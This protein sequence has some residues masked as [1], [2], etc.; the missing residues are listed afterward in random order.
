MNDP[1][2][3]S[4]S[5]IP[6]A[7]R[8]GS[9][10]IAHQGSPDAAAPPATTS[11]PTSVTVS[12]PRPNSRPTG[13]MCHGLVTVRVTRPR[14]RLRK[15]RLF[16]CSS[17][18]AS[19]YRPVRIVR[20]TLRIPT[21]AARLMSPMATRKIPDTVVPQ[22]P[23]ICCSVDWSSSI[24]P[25]SA[26]IPRASRATMMKT[27]ELWPRLNQNPTLNG[28]LPSV[29]S[30]RVVLSMAAMWSASKACRRP[31]VYA[32][33]PRPMLNSCPLTW[34]SC[35]ATRKINV[36]HPTMCSSR[37]K[38]AIPMTDRRS[39]RVISRRRRFAFA[40]VV[41]VVTPSP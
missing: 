9:V 3:E 17:S 19:T 33:T 39:G 8:T 29:I 13:Y 23:V 27:T 36:P 7:K 28:R 41:V 16:S 24:A 30:F 35:G 15:P 4:S 40:G 21:S 14:I 37:M 25:A 6:A 26:R 22:M 10:R 1:S 12:N 32:V 31:R 18:S 2:M 38:V 5:D 20:N 11:S 34:Y